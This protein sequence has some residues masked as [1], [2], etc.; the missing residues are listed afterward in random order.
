M[1][2]LSQTRKNR[3]Y[4][5]IHDTECFIHFNNLFTFCPLL[6][7]KNKVIKY[8]FQC[9]QIPVFI[10]LVVKIEIYKKVVTA[11]YPIIPLPRIT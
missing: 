10:I 11:V 6:V 4:K 7:L 9:L 3:L 1:N 8:P 2:H 5:F